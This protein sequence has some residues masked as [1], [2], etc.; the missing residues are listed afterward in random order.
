MIPFEGRKCRDIPCEWLPAQNLIPYPRE[1][2]ATKTRYFTG[3]IFFSLFWIGMIIIGAVGLATGEPKRLSKME[4][5]WRVT[6]AHIQCNFS[7]FLEATTKEMFVVSMM[8]SPTQS[9]PHTPA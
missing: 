1:L 6:S 7:Q 4:L 5:L 9:S 8:V 3:C 2:T